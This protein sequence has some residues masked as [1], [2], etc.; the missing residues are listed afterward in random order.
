MDVDSIK[1][2]TRNVWGFGDYAPLSE[3][4][5]PAA[6]ELCAACA[7]SAGQEVLDV[8]AGDGNFAIACAREGASVVA[9]D[10]APV[11]VE[12]G[13]ARAAA[14][15]YEIKWLEADVEALPFD[16]ASFD[17]VGSVFG[18]MIAPRPRVVAEE[19]FRVVRPGGTVGMTAW[20]PGTF[21]T[22]LFAIA[23]SYGPPAPPEQPLSEEW[24]VEEN[25]RE[26]FDGLAVRFEI[27]TRSLTWEGESPEAI[28]DQMGRSAPTWVAARESLPADRFESLQA[29]VIELFRRWGGD[30]PVSIEN[31]YAVIVA[32]K[33]G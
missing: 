30:G 18:A 25:V 1:Q 28:A 33:R 17:C 6:L 16:D 3:L 19:L 13:R 29:E 8:A 22:E 20:V 31:K 15:G 14:E 4:L 9:S 12:R 2:R 23:R 7:V 24:A 27:E 10:I 11:M 32:R 26:R 5:R 21:S